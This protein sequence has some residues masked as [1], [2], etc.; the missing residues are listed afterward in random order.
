MRWIFYLLVVVNVVVA[1]T[2]VVKAEVEP[3]R[4]AAIESAAPSFV[5][6]TLVLLSE[7]DPSSV[8]PEVPTERL[9]MSS[10]GVVGEAPIAEGKVL[11]G[12]GAELEQESG[13]VTEGVVDESVCSMVGP[14]KEVLRAEYFAEHLRALAVDAS[15]EAL[16]VPGGNSYWVHESPLP[17]KKMAL[18]RLHELQ[19]RDIDS[20]L[21][22]KGDLQYGIS[23]GVFSQ[24]VNASRRLEKLQALGF[25]VSVK[26]VPRFYEE[27]WVVLAAREAVKIGDE[28]WLKLLNREEN[29]KLQQ[30]YCSGVASE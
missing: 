1:V 4:S 24:E 12:Q 19:A 8:V 14:F 30:N 15:V 10:P 5:G 23:F 18:R 25:T 6:E 13:V 20:Y 26:L 29:I 22:P 7:M 11:V 16:E 28:M 2:F 3:A 9:R 17:S 21:I 27:V